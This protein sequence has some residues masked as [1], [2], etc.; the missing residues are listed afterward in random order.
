MQQQQLCM[1]TSGGESTH[2][3]DSGGAPEATRR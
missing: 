3:T 1:S 2:A